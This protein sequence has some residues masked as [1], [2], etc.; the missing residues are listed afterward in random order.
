MAQRG[1]CRSFSDQPVD[2][3]LLK[4]LCAIAF[5]A[6]SKSDL[7]QR[8]IIVITEP[9]QR[10]KINQLFPPDDWITKAP[11]LMVFCANNRR[12]RQISQSQNRPFPNDHLDAFFNASVDAA[13][14]LGSFVIA[15]ESQGLGCC[16]I[17][18]IRN[19]CEAVSEL[20][21]LPDHVFP[22]AG[23]GLGWPAAE[24][25]VSLRLPIS[26]TLHFDQFNETGLENTIAEYSQR[27][28]KV[29][30]YERQLHVEK[31]GIDDQYGWAEEKA[32]QYSEP[33]R[34]D[35]GSFIRSKGFSLK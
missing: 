22:I 14:L 4:T 34:A 12:Q 19:H 6:P 2:S 10:R 17:S 27:R 15:A 28:E 5:C 35:F 18:A 24:A 23:L 29:Q 25:D 7:Q 32:R 11:V 21:E 26:A 16:P 13:I 8:D 9:E 1:S 31:F 33:Q 20:L 30:P 3:L